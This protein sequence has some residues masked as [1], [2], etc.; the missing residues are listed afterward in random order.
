VLVR[1]SDRGL[2]YP[3]ELNGQIF[4]PSATA[5]N[6]VALVVYGAAAN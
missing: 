1:G 4:I 6:K 2:A 5:S 3:F